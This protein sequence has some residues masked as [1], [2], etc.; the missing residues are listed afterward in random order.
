[1]SPELDPRGVGG[2]QLGDHLCHLGD[3]YPMPLTASS[4]GGGG[5]LT[6]DPLGQEMGKMPHRFQPIS[7]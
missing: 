1:M 6:C 7:T 4:V 3:V 2:Q 5:A